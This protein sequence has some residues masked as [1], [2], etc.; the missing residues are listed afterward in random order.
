MSHKTEPSDGSTPAE[1]AERRHR[2]RRAIEQIHAHQP[3]AVVRAAAA[4]LW[5]RSRRS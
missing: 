2:F 1:L 5:S 3:T 4:D